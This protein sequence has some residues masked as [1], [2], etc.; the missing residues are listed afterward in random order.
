MKLL[1]LAAG[2]ATRL[3]PLTLHHAKPLLEVAGR[4]MIEHVLAT[5]EGIRGLDHIFVVA[6]GKFARDFEAWAD[7]YRQTHPNGPPITVVN[8][9]STNDSNKLGAIGDINLVIDSQKVADDLLVVGADNLFTEPLDRFVAFARP[10]GPAVCMYDVGDLELVKK[11]SVVVVDAAGR[12]LEFEEKPAAPHATLAA[13]CVYYYPH[14]TLPLIGQYLRDGNNPDQPGRLV[15]WLYQRQPVY[16]HQI[17]G[18]WMDIGSIEQ[19]ELARRMFAP[20]KRL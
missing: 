18:P 14:A 17:H 8:D 7:A 15:A 4:P 2:Y 13:I 19:L 5:T 3:Y 6:N 12:L 9:H 10:R 16:A 1:I 11:Y 20:R